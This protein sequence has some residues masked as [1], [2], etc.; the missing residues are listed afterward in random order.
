MC[1]G[2]RHLDWGKGPKKWR[3]GWGNEKEW[4][5]WDRN[6]GRR[7]PVL[8][9]CCVVV[10]CLWTVSRV[11]QLCNGQATGRGKRRGKWG[12]R[13]KMAK[14]VWQEGLP[15]FAGQFWRRWIQASKSSS[16]STNYFIFCLCTFFIPYLWIMRFSLCLEVRWVYVLYSNVKS[17]ICLK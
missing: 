11:T 9:G 14:D 10:K 1:K 8:A 13:G 3:N 17:Y 15:L 12:S 4:E 6:L 5:K 16:D 7:I 2:R